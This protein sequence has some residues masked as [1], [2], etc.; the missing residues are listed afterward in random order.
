MANSIAYTKNYTSVLDEVYQREACSTCLNSPRRMARAGK[1]AKEIMVPKIQ[2]SGLGDYTRNVGYKTGSITY[3]YETKTFN[4]DRGIKLL[5][6]V[7]DVEE[8]GVLDCF[9]EAGSELQRLQVAPEAD[10]FTFSEIAGHEGVSP[11]EEDFSD[12]DAEDVLAS[13]RGAT[14][15]MDEAQVTTGSRILFITPTLKG[16]LDDFSLANPARSNRVLERFSRIVEVPQVRFYSAI[17]LLPG[18]D[19]QFG[20]ARAEGEY[21]KTT[22]SSVV[23]GKTYYTES[24]GSYTKVA[25]PSAGSLSTYYELVGA[26][27]PINY[28]VVERSAVIK[29]DKHVASRVFSPDELENLDSYMMKYRKYGIVEL[30]DNKLD[31]VHVSCAPLA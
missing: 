2:V 24:G 16:V 12:A 21:V 26:G 11:A 27:A 8:S 1:N 22:D 9:V 30:L 20:Y 18:D 17:D 19:D 5:A 7:M 29:F 6:D 3:E 10:A 4:Y 15:A 28:M 25:S 14:N 23:S 31:G 13:L